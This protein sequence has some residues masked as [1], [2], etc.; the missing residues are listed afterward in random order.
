MTEL[1]V[2]GETSTWRRRAEACASFQASIFAYDSCTRAR[3]RAPS[4]V[5]LQA[6]R[7]SPS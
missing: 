6:A 2:E 3:S 4:G 7:S 1:I 5:D